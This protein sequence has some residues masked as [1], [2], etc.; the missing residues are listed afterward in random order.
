MTY[1]RARRAA[2][3]DEADALAVLDDYERAARYLRDTL[4][5]CIGTP[6]A[7]TIENDLTAIERKVAH[8]EDVVREMDHELKARGE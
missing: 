6:L 5:M 4:T 7:E 1:A 8:W 2:L 3:Q